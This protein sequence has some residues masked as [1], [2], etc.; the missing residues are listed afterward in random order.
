MVLRRWAAAGLDGSR[1]G[2]ELGSEAVV[3]AHCLLSG[4]VLLFLAG[5]SHHGPVVLTLELSQNH[6]GGSMTPRWLGPAL[7]SLTQVWVGL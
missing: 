3:R 2:E 7:E 6:P 4:L 1:V 5:A